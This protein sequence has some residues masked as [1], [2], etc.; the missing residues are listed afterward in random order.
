MTV[1]LLGLAAALTII[2]LLMIA[3]ARDYR[4]YREKTPPPF[5]RRLGDYRQNRWTA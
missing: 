1:A 4:R 2:T 5:A 3:V